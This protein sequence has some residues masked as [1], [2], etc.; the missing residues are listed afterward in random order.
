MAPM[1]ACAMHRVPTQTLAALR[2][3]DRRD[4]KKQAK[5]ACCVRVLH[6]RGRGWARS[7]VGRPPVHAARVQELGNSRISWRY[8]RIVGSAGNNARARVFGR[9]GR[10]K[11]GDVMYD[12]S[13]E[14]RAWGDVGSFWGLG[15]ES[16]AA[17]RGADV[18]SRHQPRSAPVYAS[19]VPILHNIQLNG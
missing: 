16:G 1:R 6:C 4:G 13:R 10:G 9:G 15:V 19:K 3:R 17:G 8:E 18:K 7:N 14:I 5:S 2:T 12:L 11:S